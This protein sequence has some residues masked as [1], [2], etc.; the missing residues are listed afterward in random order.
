MNSPPLS[1]L[2]LV[3]LSP[4]PPLKIS[5]VK[6]PNSDKT[7]CGKFSLHTKIKPPKSNIFG[8]LPKENLKKLFSEQ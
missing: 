5:T 2:D 8:S 6:S 7:K 1:V 4:K 3:S